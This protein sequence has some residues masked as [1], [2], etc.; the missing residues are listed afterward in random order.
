[1]L[2]Y[3]Q[4]RHFAHETYA[5]ARALGSGRDDA[6]DLAVQVALETSWAPHNLD[7]LAALGP[8]AD[9]KKR[10]RHNLVRSIV[11]W[12]E[13]FG[14]DDTVRTLV[15]PDGRVAAELSWT[16]P[17]PATAPDGSTYL[18]CGHFDRLVHF[19]GGNYVGEYKTTTNQL[20]S[21]YFNRFSPNT[22]V[23]TYSAAGQIYVPDG[24]KGVLIEAEQVGVGFSRFERHYAHRSRQQNDEWMRTV[25]AWIK[26][27]ERDAEDLAAGDPEAFPQNQSACGNYGGCQFRGICNMAPSQREKFLEADFNREYW[28]PLRTR[29][30]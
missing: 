23:S 6:L 4:C 17:L 12:D 8:K 14:D 21:F 18:L 3:G 10:T 2:V 26:R 5:K 25:M 22:Q 20:S 7:E 11:W 27:A 19:T 30:D 28:D 13:E 15:L 16:L 1:M 29:G 24:I 9:A